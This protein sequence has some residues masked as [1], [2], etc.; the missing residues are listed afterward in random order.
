MIHDNQ[1]VLTAG[2][3]LTDAKAAVIMVHG[4]G[5]SARD[6]LQLAREFD[7]SQIAVLAPQAAGNTWYPYRFIEPIEKNEPYLSSALAK[8]GSL[9]SQVNTAGIPTEKIVLLGFSQGGCL[10]VEYGARNPQ[11]Y[12]G[13]VGLSGGLIGELGKPLVYDDNA[14]IKGTP[15]FLGCDDA[16]F[17]IPKE[18]VEESAEVFRKMKGEVTMRLYQGMGH[19]ISDDEVSFIRELITG[20]VK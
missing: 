10:A 18:R 7:T 14:N 12:G 19:T 17:H 15:V 3:N 16:D 8:V 2:A 5:A 9:I 20:L 13:L 11:R 6:I 4:R 1:P